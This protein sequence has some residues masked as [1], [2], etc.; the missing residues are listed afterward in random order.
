MGGNLQI[1]SAYF[2][3]MPYNTTENKFVLSSEMERLKIEKKAALELQQRK[4]EDWNDNYELYRNKFFP[5][6][7]S[8]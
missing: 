2:I 8:L 7:Q 5:K 4:H 1:V 6:D 3:F